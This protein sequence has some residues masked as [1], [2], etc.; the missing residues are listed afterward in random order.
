MDNS[1]QEKDIL[2]FEFNKEKLSDDY[3]FLMQKLKSIKKIIN[4]LEK[5]FLDKEI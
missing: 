2:N 3:K 4:L 5:N 1:D